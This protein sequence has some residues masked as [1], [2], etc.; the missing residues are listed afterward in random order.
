MRCPPPRARPSPAY[1]NDT[2]ASSTSPRSRAG[3]APARPR[4]P[5]VPRWGCAAGR[6]CG[7]GRCCLLVAVEHL[8]Q[9]L[10][11]GEEHAQ[12]Q[13][14]RREHARRQV[15]RGQAGRADAE[16]RGRGEIGQQG[17][18]GEERGDVA[19][20]PQPGTPVGGA[21][22]A[23]RGG[24]ALLP[25]VGL[26]HPHAGHVLLQVGVDDADLLAGVGVGAR[27]QPPEHDR[28]DDQQREHGQRDQRQ[29]DV[30]EQ[31]R[32]GDA[33]DGEQADDRLGEA[34]LQERRQRVDV[35]GHPGHDAARQL[36]LVVVEPEPLQVRVAAH[37]QEVEH[38][39]PRPR[40]RDRLQ[41]DDQPARRHDRHAEQHGDHPHAGAGG[42]GSAFHRILL[43]LSG[44]ALMG[45]ASTAST[46][47]RAPS[48]PR[49]HRV[50]GRAWRSPSSSAAATSSAAGGAPG[51][52]PRDRRLRGH[53]RD[54][55]RRAHAAG[56]DRAARRGHAGAIGDPRC[57]E[58][59]EPY[60]RRRAIRHLEKGRV[61]IFGAGTGNPFFT[62][63]TAAALRAMEIGADVILKATHGV[64]RHLRR[65]P[66]GR[67]VAQLHVAL[68]HLDALERGLKVMDATAFALCRDNELRII[69]VQPATRGN[70]PRVV[71]ASP[72]DTIISSTPE[73]R[74]IGRHDRTTSRQRR[75]AG[76]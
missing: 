15:A 32:H 46:R 16:H 76:G 39:L 30:G 17:D 36:A 68:T 7:R 61:V 26:R 29:L 71:A 42:G 9:L 19:L 60:I 2:S 6:R 56:R 63:D 18:A 37:A 25:H 4:A 27:R 72:W 12:V 21:A 48:S 53:A 65:R 49:N 24:A 64:R 55:D 41:R 47:S 40:G 62:T 52:G 75:R 45:D 3:T 67:P 20:G 8:G 31:Q 33:D 54:R 58:V 50:R 69:R 10:H 51:H 70:I 73:R 74:Q 44:E 57:R 34:G 59:A 13:Q 1:A 38:A 5:A 22:L 28:R 43:K 35:G 11:R 66:A 14:E 23:E